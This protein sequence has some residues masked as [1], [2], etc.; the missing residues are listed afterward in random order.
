M[1]WSKGFAAGEMHALTA[2]LVKFCFWNCEVYQDS[3]QG[4]NLG[5]SLLLKSDR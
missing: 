3:L 5:T 2:F 1:L 4:H